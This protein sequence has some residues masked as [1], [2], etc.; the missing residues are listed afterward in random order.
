MYNQ[1]ISWSQLAPWNKLN[2]HDRS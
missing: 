2:K 1:Q